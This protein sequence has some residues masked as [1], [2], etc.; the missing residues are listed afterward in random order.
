LFPRQCFAPGSSCG[1]FSLLL[2]ALHQEEF[3][4]ALVISDSAWA[5]PGGGAQLG[6]FLILLRLSKFT[7]VNILDCD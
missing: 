3:T 6:S 2:T 4:G 7:P 5:I 1:C